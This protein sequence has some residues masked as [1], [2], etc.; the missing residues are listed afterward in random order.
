MPNVA[1]VP[2][3]PVSMPVAITKPSTPPVSTTPKSCYTCQ[4]EGCGLQFADVAGLFAHVTELGPG[5]HIIKEGVCTT[6]YM[7]S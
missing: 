6:Y 1:V 2:D 3:Q 7:L 4:W 5:S